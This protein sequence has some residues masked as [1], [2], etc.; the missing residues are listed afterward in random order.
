[1]INRAPGVCQLRAKANAGGE[2][3]DGSKETALMSAAP[4]LFAL[5]RR[6]RPCYFVKARNARVAQWIERLPF[7]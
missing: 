6:Q 4:L 2:M 7:R 5:E 1:M 3:N